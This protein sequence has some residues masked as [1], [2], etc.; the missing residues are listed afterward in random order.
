V[1]A[2]PG[3]RRRGGAVGLGASPTWGR[4]GGRDDS[5]A[6]RVSLSGRGG[7]QSGGGRGRLGRKAK[8]AAALGWLA[9]VGLQRPAA[10]AGLLRG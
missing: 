8:R 1:R 6:P 4:R 2:R 7:E 3:L 10:T 5:W 9:R